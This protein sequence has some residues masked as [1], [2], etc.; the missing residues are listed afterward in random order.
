VLW[1]TNLEKQ[2]FPALIQTFGMLPAGVSQQK[3]KSW[4][5][6]QQHQREVA[7]LIAKYQQQ[8]MTTSCTRMLCMILTAVHSFIAVLHGQC[9]HDAAAS[10]ALDLVE[11]V[12]R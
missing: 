3:N 9:P 12:C 7:Q 10:T 11:L 1:I 8:S 6:T 5:N 4:N 2:I